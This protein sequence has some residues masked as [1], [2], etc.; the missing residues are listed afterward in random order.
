MVFGGV[1][2][3]IL[4]YDMAGVKIRERGVADSPREARSGTHSHEQDGSSMHGGQSTHNVLINED[5]GSASSRSAG[6][7]SSSSSKS[8]ST[9][10]LGTSV[11]S[12]GYVAVPSD[13]MH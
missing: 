4:P 13:V 5:N 6:S 7:A 1:A 8:S 2:S 10:E 11:K 9:R 3:Y 12:K